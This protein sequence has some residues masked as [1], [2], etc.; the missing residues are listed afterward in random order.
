MHL[1]PTAIIDPR[2]HLGPDVE[3]GP[4][5]VIGPDVSLGAGCVIGPHVVIEGPTTL[6][7]G[8]R[9]SPFAAL[10]GPPQDR[11]Y[12]GEPTQLLVGARAQIREHV[13]IHRG[14][15]QGA[16][17]TQIG[18]D[19]L[20]MASSHIAHDCIIGQRVTLANATLLAGHV[21]LHDDVITGGAVAIHQHVTIGR[22]AFLA[23][24][25]MVERDVPPFCRAAG[26]RAALVGLN[27]VG[28]QRAALPPDA[29]LALHRAYK[30]LFRTDTPLTAALTLTSSTYP[31]DPFI[32]HLLS[33]IHDS[34][35][36]DRLLCR[37]RLTSSTDLP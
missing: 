30:A 12:A 6:G 31:D 14:T 2:A 33:F 16:G 22:L 20:I 34:L 28:L 17:H 18:D 19:A 32:Q 10:G 21:T 15:I 23:A 26:D 1:H 7:P 27:A 4:F 35:Q 8:C 37:P 13:T 24:N 5:S 25:A 11:K 3:V 29:I 9:V 36:R